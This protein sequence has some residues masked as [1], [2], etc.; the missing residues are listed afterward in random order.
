MERTTITVA[1]LPSSNRVAA[2]AATELDAGATVD[3]AEEADE[4]VVPATELVE[5]TA[6]EEVLVTR[7]EDPTTGVLEA[8]TEEAPTGEEP[9]GTGELVGRGVETGATE[10]IADDEAAAQVESAVSLTLTHWVTES[11]SVV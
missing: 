10:E 9:E 1:R 6:D 2:L 5:A 11:L 4:A 8:A 3:E 7:L